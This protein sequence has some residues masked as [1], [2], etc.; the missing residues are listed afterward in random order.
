MTTIKYPWEK[1]SH[2]VCEDPYF[3]LSYSKDPWGSLVCE[4]VL[5]W[6]GKEIPVE[7][8]MLHHMYDVS[9]TDSNHY[10]DRLLT[11]TWKYRKG[12]LILRIEED[13]IFGNRYEELIFKPTE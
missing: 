12:N 6:N 4:E 2:W 7:V 5:I 11:G 1:A 8:G 13:F 9:P 3:T 10:D